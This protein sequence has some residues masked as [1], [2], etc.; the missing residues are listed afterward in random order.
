VNASWRLFHHSSPPSPLTNPWTIS[1]NWTCPANQR[2]SIPEITHTGSRPPSAT[3]AQCVSALVL[4]PRDRV[5]GLSFAVSGR[6]VP[7]RRQPSLRASLWIGCFIPGPSHLTTPRL[8]CQQTYPS[9]S[10][11]SQRV[12]YREGPLT[13]R[14]LSWVSEGLSA[15]CLE[16]L[17]LAP[18][19]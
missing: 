19:A 6:A 8:A 2:C 5:R 1:Q 17:W 7:G 11:W 4:V 18:F 12:R 3:G 15:S 16:P 13:G 14:E 9:S 10:R